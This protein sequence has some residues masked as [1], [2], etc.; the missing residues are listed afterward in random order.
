MAP[1]IFSTSASS[2]SATTTP[3][4]RARASN[5]APTWNSSACQVESLLGEGAVPMT[6]APMRDPL[7]ELS[8]RRDLLR[9][10]KRGWLDDGVEFE[11]GSVG[12]V[13]VARELDAPAGLIV[14]LARLKDAG[15]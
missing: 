5:A 4:C 10:G 6:S 1:T 8:A 7:A 11:G 14:C 15:G 3:D 2:A 9:L 13:D 12:P